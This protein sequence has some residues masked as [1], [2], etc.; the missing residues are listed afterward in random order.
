MF[1]ITKS[2]RHSDTI[3]VGVEQEPGRAVGGAPAAAAPPPGSGQLGIT[4]RPACWLL[5]SRSLV[6][7]GVSKEPA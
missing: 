3:G 5:N 2:R 1:F 4:A 7:D 6:G